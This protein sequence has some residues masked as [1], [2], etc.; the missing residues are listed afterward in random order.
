MSSFSHYSSLYLEF[1]EHELKVTTLYKYIQIVSQRINP[2]FGDRN[3]QDIKPSDIK[4]WL[5]SIDDVGSKSKRHYMGVLSGIFQEALYDEVIDKNPVKFVKLPKH[6][7]PVI[8]PFSSSQVKLILDFAKEGNF[9]F[10]LAIAFFT[11]L[12]SGEILG[13]KKIDIDF[14]K[15]VLHVRRSRNKHGESTP[16][17]SGS[18][19]E[20]PIIDSLKP[21][22]IDLISLHDYEY[23]FITYAKKPYMDTNAFSNCFWKPLLLDLNISYRRLY[24]T[25]HTFATNMLLNNLVSPLQLSQLLG[26]SS[27]QMVYEVYVRF[28]DSNYQ[29]FDRTI[30]I[31]S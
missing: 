1:K 17:T 12:R 26:H 21:Y 8:K 24:N 9:R 20:V 28:L 6:N 19:R 25:R 31:Y 18:I 7:K 4:K 30:T 27:T 5:Y 2:V 14:S 16:K 15:N 22:L 11:G 3:I 29:D 13:L 23:L 10:Y